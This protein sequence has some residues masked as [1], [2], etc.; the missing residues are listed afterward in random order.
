MD[1]GRTGGRWGHFPTSP[2]LGTRP[3][4]S[5]SHE[6][7]SGKTAGKVIFPRAPGLSV[8]ICISICSKE[9]GKT[10]FQATL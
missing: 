4:R 7:Q 3:V 9:D 6:P 1:V 8:H 10:A 5:S 2:G